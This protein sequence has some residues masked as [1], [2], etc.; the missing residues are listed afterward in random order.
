[1]LN[2][3]LLSLT[4]GTPYQLT[5]SVPIVTWESDNPNVTVAD[6]E[7]LAN[8]DAL[9]PD[10]QA[11]ITATDAGG[12]TYTCQVTIVPWDVDYSKLTVTD[13]LPGRFLLGQNDGWLYYVFANSNTLYRTNNSM[14]SSEI[15]CILPETMPS[16]WYTIHAYDLLFTPLGTYWQYQDKIYKV[17]SDFSTWDLVYT[18]NMT[19][20]GHSFCFYYD[21]GI[22]T[23][24]IYLGEYST[25][26]ANRHAVYRGVINSET[27]TWSKILDF[28]SRDEY[29]ADP[30]DS[31]FMA[32]HIHV[33]TVDPYT[34]HVWVN[35]GDSDHECQTMYSTD[36]GDT[37][38]PLGWGS[39]SWRSLAI[40]FTENYIYWNMDTAH[41]QYVYRIPKTAFVD[42]EYPNMNP[43]L[44][45]G[46]TIVGIQYQVL[47][48]S[49]SRFPVGAGLL[50]TETEARNL[51]ATHSVRPTYDPAYDYKDIV[52]KLDNGS[53]WFYGKVKNED[54]E[55]VVLMASSTEG[56]IR[57]WNSRLISFKEN[58]ALVEVTEVLIAESWTPDVYIWDNR[59]CR[60]FQDDNGYVFA[61]GYKNTYNGVENG[62][63]KMRFGAPI[64][65]KSL[66]KI[67]SRV[68]TSLK[69]V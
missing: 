38:K 2:R 59:W 3:N 36:N 17:S 28:K 20:I 7:L 43:P 19:G 55:D 41:P 45:A 22:D 5:S 64:T 33:V 35:T 65:P 46:Q 13:V 12:N 69:N 6:G 26:T 32:R 23:V 53:H 37:F 52:A 39:Q 61:V 54:D 4:V 42:G 56:E 1:M 40:W 29:A 67:N 21:E 58:G 15:V 62:L 24:Y 31:I 57:D 50:Y 66:Q 27:E 9:R 68:F 16:Y 8:A 10:G 18:V 47:E 14:I 11:V 48:D 60:I 30:A 49:T 34:G 44:L 25:D 63:F 51:D